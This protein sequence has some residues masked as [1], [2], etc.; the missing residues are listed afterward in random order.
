M[1][2]PRRLRGVERAGKP[3]TQI[4]QRPRVPLPGAGGLAGRARR[5]AGRGDATD[6]ELVQVATLPRCSSPTGRALRRGRDASSTTRM[7]QIA[8][9][10]GGTVSAP[11]DR[12]GRRRP[13]ALLHGH[14][15]RPR[16]RVHVRPARH[17]R[18]PAALPAQG[19][20]TA[21]TPAGSCSR[22]SRRLSGA[23]ALDLL[24]AARRALRR[25]PANAAAKT[26]SIVSAGMNSSASRV[27][28]G[29]SSRSGSFSRGKIDALQ[30]GALRGERLLAQ[31]ADRQ[32][33]PGQRDLAGHADVVRDRL[34]AHERRDRRRHRHAGRRAVLRHRAGRARGCARRARRTS[35][36]AGRARPCASAPTRAPPAPTP[37]SPRRAG[38]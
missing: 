36:P 3:P 6:S 29:S 1:P 32:H 14:G 35:R 12:H 37:A 21:T 33:L 16:R 8:Q 15:R 31:A 23:A 24:C 30:A 13:L 20:A 2:H 38:R 22:A 19:V 27:S 10:T 9:Q 5:R 18:V 25:L 4:V 11:R 26:S 17:A 28:G 34:A 7:R